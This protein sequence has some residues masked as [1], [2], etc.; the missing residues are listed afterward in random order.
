MNTLAVPPLHRIPSHHSWGVCVGGSPPTL[1]TVLSSAFSRVLCQKPCFP[2][3]L[4][5]AW[6]FRFCLETWSVFFP[7]K[8]ESFSCA[9]LGRRPNA[10]GPHFLISTHFSVLSV[11]L[12]LAPA[13]GHSSAPGGVPRTHP[14]PA[15]PPPQRPPLSQ[16]CC[17]CLP[18]AL[19]SVHS[20]SHH[21][22][23]R[24][25]TGACSPLLSRLEA[26]LPPPRPHFHL[27]SW[28]LHPIPKGTHHPLSPIGFSC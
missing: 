11:G 7:S 6:L 19:S 5:S 9:H 14:Q 3:F 4:S 24:T 28:S 21:G 18:Q 23:L 22:P 17:V 13:T 2:S 26:P 15:F 16:S 27:Q 25:Q 12:P 1:E 8:I 10:F 20:P